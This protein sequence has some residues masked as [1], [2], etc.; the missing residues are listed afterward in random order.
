MESIITLNQPVTAKVVFDSKKIT[1]HSTPQIPEGYLTI[2]EFRTR[3]TQE[4]KKFCEKYG[5]H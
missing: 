2:E 1:N 5:I 4:T 3:A